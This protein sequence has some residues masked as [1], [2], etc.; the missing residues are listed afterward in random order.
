MPLVSC[1]RY[2][3]TKIPQVLV[4]NNTWYLVY[5]V[6]ARERLLIVIVATC[7]PQRA[8]KNVYT[9]YRYTY[10]CM[11]LVQQHRTRQPPTYSSSGS[12]NVARKRAIRK[13]GCD[14]YT[15]N[16]R[17][18]VRTSSYLLYVVWNHPFH[19]NKKSTAC[20]S[21]PVCCW[22]LSCTAGGQY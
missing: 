11:Y 16:R 7:N 17:K 6:H 13:A 15:S 9:Y 4:Y 14:Y 3:T 10:E 19:Q 2:I 21:F 8:K 22:L 20:A 18:G 12:L 1:T 5:C